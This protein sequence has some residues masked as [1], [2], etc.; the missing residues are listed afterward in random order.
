M[1]TIKFVVR[2]STAKNEKFLKA[3]QKLDVGKIA[4]A[5][6]KVGVQALAR[7]TPRDTGV[8]QKGWS[9]EVPKWGWHQ[10]YLDQQEHRERLSRS[11]H[12]PVWPRNRHRGLR[13]RA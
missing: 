6:A 5:Q 3:M 13:P 8:A 2:G 12:A 1:R 4:S 9:Y 11:H 7:A 10:H